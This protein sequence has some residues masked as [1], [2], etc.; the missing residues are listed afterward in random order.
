MS[1]ALREHDLDLFFVGRIAERGPQREPVEL[2]LRQRERPLLLDRVLRR[3]HEEGRR[4]HARDAVHGHLPFR[5]RLEQRRLRARH[6]AVDLVDEDDV[7]ED[8][9]GPELELARLLV[10]DREPGDV[11]R[12]QVRCALDARE[13]GA[14]DRLRERARED[15]LRRSRHVLEQDV[16]A[17]RERREH[18]RDLL[19]L[20]EDDPLDVR[21]QPVR[22]FQG[23]RDSSGRRD[24]GSF[25]HGQLKVP[26]R[27]GRISAGRRASRCRARPCRRAPL[28]RR[29]G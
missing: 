2:R 25:R 4:Q 28:A 10:V 14:A 29:R 3:D 13:A 18:E 1:V 20:A 21:D 26:A 8:R 19:V 9:T 22:D 15:R 23:G 6:R 16:P 7:R 5:H 17:A 27:A 11:G 12:L 24:L